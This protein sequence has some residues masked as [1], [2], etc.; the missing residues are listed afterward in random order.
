MKQGI[1]LAGAGSAHRGAATSL[2]HI[3][4]RVRQRWPGLPCVA[5][6]TSGGHGRSG[7]PSSPSAFVPSAETGLDR[8]A[9]LGV[10]HAVIQSLHII[11]GQEYHRLLRLAQERRRAEV[12]ERVEVGFPLLG[13]EADIEA[14]ARAVLR[15][16][17][18]RGEGGQA[19][20]LMGHGTGHPG[21]DYYPAL[22]E[23]LTQL[24]P[25]VFMATMDRE[26]GLD[27]VLARLEDLGAR[28]VFLLPLLFGAGTHASR[29]LAGH[30]GQASSW[31]ARL[32]E[33]GV[34]CEPVL[35]GAGEYDAFADIWMAHLEQALSAC[36]P[37]REGD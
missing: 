30:G 14:V 34:A 12:F 5:A 2:E 28:K 29:D 6:R 24:D 25:R 17:P 21:H 11:P 20:L 18:E 35:K 1:L 10:T 31:R 19:V 22:A 8:L 27:A 23:R 37:D 7:A 3:L 36:G 33:R 13:G 15:V 16:A 26:P 4:R 9:E 32:E